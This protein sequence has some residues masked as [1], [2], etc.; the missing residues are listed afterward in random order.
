[1]IEF[2]VGDKFAELLRE[3]LTDAEWQKM[4]KDNLAEIDAN[5]CHSHDYCDANMIMQDALDEF[6]M[7]E[8]DRDVWTT[9]WDYA[10]IKYLCGE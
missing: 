2:D 8:L 6:G 1:M 4:C 7:S 10:A 3:R 9:A 5:I